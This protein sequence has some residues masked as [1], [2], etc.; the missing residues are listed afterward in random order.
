[1]RKGKK[2]CK[3]CTNARFMKWKHESGFVEYQKEH[4]RENY[5][6]NKPKQDEYRKSIQPKL[7]ARSVERRKTD[8]NFKL[9][10][11]LRNRVGSALKSGSAV[12]DLGC[13]IEELKSY[14]ESKFQPG[15]T[16]ENH[17]K[18]HIDHIKPLCKFDLTNREQFIQACHFSNLQPLWAVDNIRKGGKLVE[19]DIIVPD[20]DLR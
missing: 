5:D 8:L 11:L 12:K 19:V 1:M 4:Y 20:G 16:W 3:A 13:S 2:I 10:G 18:W 14:L 17:G 15:M 7:N 6:K 9:R